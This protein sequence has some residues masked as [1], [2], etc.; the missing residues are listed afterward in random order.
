[1]GKKCY[2]QGPSAEQSP[3]NRS[4]KSDFLRQ[5]LLLPQPAKVMQCPDL[6]SVLP[7]LPHPPPLHCFCLC[8]ASD[9]K[10]ILEQKVLSR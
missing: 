5:V 2:A 9:V 6:A 10:F 3:E 8:C 1:M 4:S 7:H